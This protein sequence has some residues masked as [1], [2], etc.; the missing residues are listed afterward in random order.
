M[1][2]EIQGN[3]AEEGGW[4]QMVLIRGKEI[5]CKEWGPKGGLS[6]VQL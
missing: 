4:N 5:S 3:G 1:Y 6:P 2:K